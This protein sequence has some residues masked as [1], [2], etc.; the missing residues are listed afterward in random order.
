MEQLSDNAQKAV[1]FVSM[2]W[3]LQL[4]AVWAIVMTAVWVGTYMGTLAMRSDVSSALDEL[5]KLNEKGS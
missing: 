4:L 1:N 5:E 3:W 2:P